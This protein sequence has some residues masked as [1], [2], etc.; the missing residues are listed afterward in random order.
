MANTL[1]K[2]KLLY[3][4]LSDNPIA[5][6]RK[7]ANDLAISIGTINS[8]IK[9]GI[10]NSELKVT[11]ISYR[12]KKYQLTIKGKKLC[13][14]S[15]GVK[16]AVI[17]SAGEEKVFNHPRSFIDLDGE[18]LLERHIR[19]L[20]KHNIEN[21]FVIIGKEDKGYDYFKEKYNVTFVIN[22]D[23]KSTGTLH[24]LSLVNNIIKQDFILIEGDLIYEEQAI[25]SLINDKTSNCTIISETLFKDD[26]VYVNIKDSNLIRISKDRYSLGSISGEFVGITKISYPFFIKMMQEKKNHSNPLLFYEYVLERVTQESNMKCLIINDLL[27]SE[28]DNQ[29][30][31]ENAKEINI[32]IKQKDGM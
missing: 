8:L 18:M 4:Y 13:S 24:S 7:M 1:S 10:E 12:E 29:K 16:T 6:Q 26:S 9:G 3:R 30:Q 27:W 25:K 15:K 21:I 23:Y 22:Q 19:L 32:Q 17:L 5:S 20:K 2:R 31:L 28:I 14:L 11:D